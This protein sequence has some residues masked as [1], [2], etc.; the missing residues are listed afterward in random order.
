MRLRN[1]ALA[2]LLC[3]FAGCQGVYALTLSQLRTEIRRNIRDTG[4][5]SADQRYSDS[6]LL[7]YINEAQREIVNVTWLLEKTTEYALSSRTT[8]YALPN[9]TINVI[10]V[11]FTNPGNARYVIDLDE[12][13]KSKL[14]SEM[15][16]W[17]M[18]G[19]SPVQYLVDQGTFSS[20]ASAIPLRISYIPIP[21]NLSTGTVK[22]WYYNQP[23]DLASDS[24][25]P[26]DGKQHL[27]PYH[28][29][30][31]YY[32]AMRLKAI[33]GRGDESVLYMNLYSS[34]LKLIQRAIGSMPNYSPGMVGG[35]K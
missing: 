25:I 27:V 32:V 2:T 16:N 12:T 22:L 11:K 35:S 5:T 4:S 15:P 33:E 14:K 18:I 28:M 3:F 34:A 19:G 31:A 21:T 29:T 10:Q 7:S 20:I 30:I 6:V 8:Y 24:D 1:S 23:T 13:S 26:F 9:D 17:E